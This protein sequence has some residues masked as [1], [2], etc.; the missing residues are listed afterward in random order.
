[1]GV[2][3]H[4]LG[5][6]PFILHHC[7]SILHCYVRI[8]HRARPFRIM[9]PVFSPEACRRH[10]DRHLCIATIRARRSCVELLMSIAASE[11]WMM[12]LM[13]RQQAPATPEVTHNDA[14]HT[15]IQHHW[16][17]RYYVLSC[18]IFCIHFGNLTCRKVQEA[19]A[20]DRD[21]F[22]FDHSLGERVPAK[23]EGVG[24]CSCRRCC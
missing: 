15:L 23:F 12:V 11:T 24:A 6:T 18:V 19:P 9:T 4:G 21:K 13:N 1:M 7:K 10:V 14:P 17:V 20:L 16:R 2:R 22:I 5:P 3:H 8:R